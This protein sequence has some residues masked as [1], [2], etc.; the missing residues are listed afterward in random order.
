[1]ESPPPES[2]PP[3]SPAVRFARAGDVVLPDLLPPAALEEAGRALERPAGRGGR[4]RGGVRGLLDRF[5]AVRALAVRPEVRG[6][7]AAVLGGAPAAVRATLFDKTAEANWTVPWH[8]DERVALADRV[9][10]PAWTD[11][12]RS[13]GVW[14]ARPPRA[15]LLRM[16]AVRVH[17]DPCGPGAGPL[18]VRPGSHRGAGG[19]PR[20]CAVPAGGAV[21][22]CPAL[23]HASGKATAPGRRRVIHIEYAPP[24]PPGGACWRH[25][26][27][28]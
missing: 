17:L 10:D 15:F 14:T 5:P 16:A 12:K 21:V 28:P 7:A 25:A 23:L 3:E 26:L 22:I 27:T 6:A 18:R 24:G 1:M 2:P 20:V 8:P 9:D 11:W 13:G 19:P 4:R